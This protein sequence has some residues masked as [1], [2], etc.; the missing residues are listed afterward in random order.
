MTKE[1]NNTFTK[2]ERIC[3]RKVI[4][5]LSKN[6]KQI[7]NKDKIISIKYVF[8]PKIC[9]TTTTQIL[10]IVP[11][12]NIKLATKRNKIK[13]IIRETYRLNKHL[14]QKKENCTLLIM[15]T[16]RAHVVHNYNNIKTEILQQIIHIV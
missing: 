2:E 12:K 3:K 8:I 5:F 6:G 4:S 10:I 9:N 11:K 16:Y 7:H 13:R 1:L 14:L 15:F